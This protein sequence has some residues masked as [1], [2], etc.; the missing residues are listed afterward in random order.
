VPRRVAPAADGK[1]DLTAQHVHLG[2]LELVQRSR[3]CDPDQSE[4]RVERAGLVPGLCRG[5][6]QPRPARRLGRQL[7]RSLQEGGRRRQA[8]AASRTL[9]RALELRGDVLVEPRRRVRVMPR[10]AIGIDLGI[11]RVRQRAV[12]DLAL[13]Q[14]CPGIDR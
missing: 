12:R 11:G 6:R 5:Q 7:G 9:S 2:A 8:A 1:R 3:L 4:C 14:W 13:L 10:A